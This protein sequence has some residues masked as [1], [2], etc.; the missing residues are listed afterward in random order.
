MTDASAWRGTAISEI[1]G[2]PV[3][4]WGEDWRH[5]C[6]ARFIL[7]RLQSRDQRR[8]YLNCNERDESTGR[9]RKGIAQMRGQAEA[10]RLHATVMKIVEARKQKR[11]AA[12]AG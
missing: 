7:D 2:Q 11:E 1:T 8:K 5:E 3:D 4:S 10:D 12:E 9:F 6:E